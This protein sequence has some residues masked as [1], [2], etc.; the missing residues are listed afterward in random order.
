MLDGAEARGRVFVHARQV[1][2]ARR[3]RLAV[4]RLRLDGLM[5]KLAR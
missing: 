3:S 4:T 2:T 1:G 5:P